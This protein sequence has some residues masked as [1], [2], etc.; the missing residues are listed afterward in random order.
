MKPYNTPQL[1]TLGGPTHIGRLGSSGFRSGE[2]HKY[3][4]RRCYLG[5]NQ[6]AHFLATLPAAAVYTAS[7]LKHAAPN[8]P[9]SRWPSLTQW[10]PFPVP[11][12]EVGFFT[13]E[14]SVFRRLV[15]ALSLRA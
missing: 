8:S 7:D 13:T 2:C 1:A 9:P 11:R 4:R 15:W 5:S 10:R 6:T 14:G 12:L 3:N